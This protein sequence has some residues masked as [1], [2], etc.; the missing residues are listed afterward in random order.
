M[1]KK[2]Y[3]IVYKE[4]PAGRV[5]AR[6]IDAYSIESAKLA[7]MFEGAITHNQMVCLVVIKAGHTIQQHHD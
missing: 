2:P 3:L 1:S 4:Y 7:V 6:Y 5:I